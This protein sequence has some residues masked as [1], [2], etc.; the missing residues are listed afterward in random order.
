[1]A[2]RRRWR[3]PLSVWLRL[4]LAPAMIAA[5][6]A[7]MGDYGAFRS[8]R[9]VNG[10]E[11]AVVRRVDMETKVLVGG[12]LRPVKETTVT[13]QVE[14]I[15]DSDGTVIVSMVD[16]GTPVKK[17]DELCRLD[18]SQLEELARQEEIL[19]IEVR[20]TCLQAQLTLE[21]ARIALHEYQDGL[22]SK[23]TKDYQVR[24]ALAQSDVARLAERAVWTEAMVAKGYSSRG[25]L[26]TD[27]QALDKA[28]HELRT[29][30]GEFRVFERFQAPKEIFTLRG[31]IKTAENNH[32]LEAARLQAQEDR[33]AYIR[34]QIENC[35]VRAP[36]DG[37]AV[38]ARRSWRSEPLA[39]GVRVYQ[40][41]ELF[42]LPDLGPMEVEI[43]VHDTIGPRV[44]VGM[45][46]SVRIASIADRIIAGRVVSII[47]F[48]IQ[49]QKEWD[50]NLRHY[51]ARVRLEETPS[52]ILPSMSAVVEI[53]S[54]PVP[55]ALVIPVESMA[56]VDG[57][58][59]CYV[60]VGGGVELRTITT[61]RASIDL[62][63]VTGGL[64]E[65][66]YVVS[67]FAAAQGVSNN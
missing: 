42:K 37:F 64:E 16:N 10:I 44:R 9:P 46:A 67:R 39:P 36:H 65:G 62:L 6:W 29:A 14:D 60:M 61:G 26:V 34:Q 66:E 11:W 12:D 22:V 56:V 3:L 19:V 27:R 2:S 53:D 18:S 59:S 55:G 8:P 58:K 35:R 1:M 47:P 54:D 33:L 25:Q 63:E 13:C 45:R 32:Q 23:L 38:H 49:N 24:I 57:R 20:S 17:G 15:T 50:E 43:S 52:G 7:A 30:E 28:K 48:P 51:L 4:I 31:Q 21:V 41:Q 40:N 5:G